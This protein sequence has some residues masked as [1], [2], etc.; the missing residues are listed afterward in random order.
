MYSTVSITVRR[1]LAALALTGVVGAL[2]GC[3]SVGGGAVD[4]SDL[5]APPPPPPAP[6]VS[7]LADWRAVI[8]PADRDRYQRRN[9]AWATALEQAN[10][11]GGNGDLAVLASL[12]D[13]AAVLD[14]PMIPEGNYRCRTIKLG[15]QGNNGSLGYVVYGWFACRI[16][17]TDQGL[18]LVK[19]TGSQRVEGIFYPESDRHMVLLGAMALADEASA[20]DY[21][22][23]PDRDVA[24]VLERVGPRRWR[25]VTPWPRFESNLDIL[26][27]VPA[28]S[29]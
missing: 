27:L 9:E 5:P 21:G 4:G 26:E 6:H 23:R 17:R 25:V 12:I 24:A 8:T 14:D 2:A 20:P 15:H 3:A 13:P 29:R 22:A 28:T 11:L 1:G 16:S 18:S 10:R 19:L 7:V